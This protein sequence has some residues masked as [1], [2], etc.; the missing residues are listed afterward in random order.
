MAGSHQESNT[1][2]LVCAASAQPLCYDNWTTTS[3]HN[4]VGST[5]MPQ[6]HTQ[7]ELRNVTLISF[8]KVTLPCFCSLMSEICDYNFVYAYIDSPS[9]KEF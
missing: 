8:I 4:S 2:H 5:E 1:R 6:S 3:P 7:Q 9:Y